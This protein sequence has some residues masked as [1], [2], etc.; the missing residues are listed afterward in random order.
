MI[1]QKGSELIVFPLTEIVSKN[2]FFDYE[3][4]YTKGMADEICPAPNVPHEIEQDVKALSAFLF[5]QMDCK[6][7][8]RFDY[9]FTEENLYFLEVN[10]IP[11]ISEAS[12][13]PQMALEY[14]LSLKGFLNIVLDNII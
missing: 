4:K 14:G 5:H 1:L 3:A 9:I 8:V 12:I 6:G 2:E 13:L 10:T 7:F 11:G